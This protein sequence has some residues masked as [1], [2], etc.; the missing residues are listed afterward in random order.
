[1]KDIQSKEDLLFLMNQFYNKL[2]IDPVVGYIFTDVAKIDLEKHLPVLADFW[3]QALFHRG[4]YKNNVL[5]IHHDLHLKSALK[6]EHFDVW[7]NHFNQSV[8]KNFMGENA[9]KIKTKALSIAT[10]MQMKVL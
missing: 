9:E 5:Q 7:L 10:V 1:M 4:S 8:D 3:E 2:V 6:K